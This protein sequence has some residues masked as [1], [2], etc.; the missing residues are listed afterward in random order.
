MSNWCPKCK[1]YMFSFENHRCPPLWKTNVEDYEDDEW[2]DL[3][4]STPK[5]AAV[6]RAEQLDAGE[7]DLLKGN[8]MTVRVQTEN[9]I[10]IY[11]VRGDLVPEY[12]ATTVEKVE[13]ET[14]RKMT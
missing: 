5:D 14:E 9:G 8:T 10:E 6:K 11:E 13:E 12:H 2:V 7:Y 4:A 3:Y 1:D